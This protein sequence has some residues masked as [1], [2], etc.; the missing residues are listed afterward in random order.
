MEKSDRDRDGVLVWLRDDDTMTRL[1]EKG[2]LCADD[3]LK[4]DDS[5]AAIFALVNQRPALSQDL[6][7]RLRY[8]DPSVLPPSRGGTH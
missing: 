3:L 4:L 1:H 6:K 2:E 5:D 7:V 8:M